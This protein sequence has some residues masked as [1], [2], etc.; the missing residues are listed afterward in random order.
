MKQ[1]I[2]LSVAIA[3]TLISCNN[4]EAAKKAE[5]QQE[6]AAQKE[7]AQLDSLTNDL[8]QTKAEIEEDVQKVEDAL[9]EIEE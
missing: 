9:K 4:N 8:E 1:I 3:C 5:A 6:A 7:A 2:L